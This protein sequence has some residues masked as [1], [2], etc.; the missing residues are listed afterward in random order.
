VI[1][2][3]KELRRKTAQ[4]FAHY[5]RPLVVALLPGDVIEVRELRRPST[6]VSIRIKDLYTELQVRKAA[7][8]R[9]ERAKRRKAKKR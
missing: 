5:K 9:A 7:A 3:K 2:L 1:A 8:L 6:A 4:N